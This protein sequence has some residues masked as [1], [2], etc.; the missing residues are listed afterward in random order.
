MPERQ[1]SDLIHEVLTV[2][3]ANTVNAYAYSRSPAGA[4]G[5]FQIIPPTYKR[6]RNKYPRQG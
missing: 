2:I 3:G 6:L 4:M 5:L 1:R